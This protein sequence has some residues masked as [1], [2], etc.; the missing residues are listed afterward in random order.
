M[1]LDEQKY[2]AIIEGIL[3]LTGD[4]G[5]DLKTIAKIIDKPMNFTKTTIEQM[6]K[7][8]DEDLSKGIHI[9]CLG[10]KY[11]F[12]TKEI[13]RTYFEK[14]VDQVQNNL[15]NA[16]LEVLAIIAYNQPITRA[17]IEEIRGV[18]SDSVVKKLQARALIKELG[19]DDSAGKPILYGV[20]EE[21]LDAFNLASLE[22]LPDLEI[23]EEQ[24]GEDLFDAKY[25]ED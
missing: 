11:K 16:A 15:S 3:F 8:Y 22:E 10:L 9:V 21:F 20:S 12:A 7:A 23:K 4:D 24:L 14:M 25:K 1:N 5:C 17:K 18:S 2:Q 6:A 13:Y 19:R